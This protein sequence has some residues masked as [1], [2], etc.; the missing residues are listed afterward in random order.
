MVA[1]QT[2]V[3]RPWELTRQ[4]L[5]E[6]ALELEKNHFREQDLRTTWHEVK[7]E[8]ITA[9]IIGF[10]RQATMGGSINPF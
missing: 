10:I 3:Q 6:L 2:V 1:L 4:D 8:E 5:K 7:N 9:R